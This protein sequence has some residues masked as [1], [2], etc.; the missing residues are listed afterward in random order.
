[1]TTHNLKTPG[2]LSRKGA[3]GLEDMSGGALIKKLYR[4]IRTPVFDQKIFEVEGDV[5]AQI[6]LRLNR[7]QKLREAIENE[8]EFPDGMP[9]KLW[10]MINGNRE[11]T[12]KAFRVSVRL[13]KDK[14][15]NPKA[16]VTER[17]GGDG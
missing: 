13:F 10:N 12:E 3:G 11:A 1:M 9:D 7:E 16:G 5:V 14:L 4:C 15:L 17:E 2:G 6:L 8:P